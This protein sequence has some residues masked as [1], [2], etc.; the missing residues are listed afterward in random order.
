VEITNMAELYG[1]DLRT[2]SKVKRLA[3]DIDCALDH[4][5]KALI[6]AREFGCELQILIDPCNDVPFP[7]IGIRFEGQTVWCGVAD[8]NFMTKELSKI[9]QS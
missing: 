7:A 2:P 3:G 9:W 8:L 6:A 1:Q 5:H 4:L